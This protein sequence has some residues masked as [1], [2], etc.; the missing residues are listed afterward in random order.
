MLINGLLELLYGLLDLMLIFEI[1]KLPTEVTNYVNTLFG[2]LETGASILANYTPLG[3]L[4]I[5]FGILLLVDA[6]IMVYHFVMWILK[7]I[8]MINIK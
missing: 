8:P 7:K 3:Y 6:A 1:P 2:Y 5:L 4:L